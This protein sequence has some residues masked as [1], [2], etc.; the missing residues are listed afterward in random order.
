MAFIFFTAIFIF[1]ILVLLIIYG[2][3]FLLFYFRKLSAK[4]NCLPAIFVNDSEVMIH[5]Y[6]YN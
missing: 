4:I 1:V 2:I 5:I 6:Q 3:T